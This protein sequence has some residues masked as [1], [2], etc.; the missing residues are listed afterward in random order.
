MDP[1]ETPEGE[2]FVVRLRITGN[3]LILTR[4]AKLGIGPT[5]LVLTP[6]TR[7]RP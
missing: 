2:R 1:F 5:P 3:R 6:W 4:D 7:V